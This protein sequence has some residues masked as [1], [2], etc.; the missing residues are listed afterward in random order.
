MAG[1]AS[2]VT[3]DFQARYWPE[4]AGFGPIFP[5]KTKPQSLLN[6]SGIRFGNLGDNVNQKVGVF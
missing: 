5:S 3:Q 1:A 6:P 4:M 2:V